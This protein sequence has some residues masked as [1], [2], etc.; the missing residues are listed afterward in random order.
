MTQRNVGLGEIDGMGTKGTGNAQKSLFVLGL[1]PYLS[2]LQGSS[3]H[4]D[5]P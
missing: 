4:L 1:S 2:S 5:L 3:R